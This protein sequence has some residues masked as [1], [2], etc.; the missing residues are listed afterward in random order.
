VAFIQRFSESGSPQRAAE[1]VE[2]V[3]LGHQREPLPRS[4]DSLVPHPAVRNDSSDKISA[5]IGGAGHD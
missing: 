2:R 5:D 3:I 1:K 4:Q